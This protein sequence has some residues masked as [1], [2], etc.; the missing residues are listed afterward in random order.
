MINTSSRNNAL[1]P[2]S[3][4]KSLEPLTMLGS[5]TKDEVFDEIKVIK[6]LI[7]QW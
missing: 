2:V 3:I 6:Q 5:M 1:A 4:S 7:P